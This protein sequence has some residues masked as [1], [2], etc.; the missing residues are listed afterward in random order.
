MPVAGQQNADHG[1][2]PQADAERDADRAERMLFDLIFGVV[3]QIFRRAAALFD[4]AFSRADPVFNCNSDSFFHAPNSHT[5]L[6]IG[7][8]ESLRLKSRLAV[9]CLSVHQTTPGALTC[10]IVLRSPPQF[11]VLRRPGNAPESRGF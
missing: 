8:C 4:G 1:S 5:K 2:Q 7:C 3:N 11:S 9:V 6:S 10:F